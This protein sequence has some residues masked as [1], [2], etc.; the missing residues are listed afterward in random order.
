MSIIIVI[1]LSIGR[2][3]LLLYVA[4]RNY[5]V[6]THVIRSNEL[7]IALLGYCAYTVYSR[8]GS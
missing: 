1:I 7:F 5:C 4:G 2:I 3:L 8:A 6:Y